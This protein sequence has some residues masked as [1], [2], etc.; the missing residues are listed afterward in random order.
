MTPGGL[1]LRVRLTPKASS[2]RVD[3]VG[4]APD[5]RPVLLAR[6]RALPEDGAANAALLALLA[7]SLKLPKSGLALDSGGRS[8]VKT[9]IVAGEAEALAETL[10]RL[11]AL[12]SDGLP[13][14]GAR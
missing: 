11:Q 1:A 2:D 13:A 8:R 5:G 14:R 3:G 9:V 10:E 12:L 4:I 6:V 7:K